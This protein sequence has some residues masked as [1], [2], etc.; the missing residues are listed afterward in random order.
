MYL[1]LVKCEAMSHFI[2]HNVYIRTAG[3]RAQY[4]NDCISYWTY[5][6]ELHEK[7]VNTIHTVTIV[8]S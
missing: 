2:Y 5:T 8:F 7:V 3:L 1:N 6:K 4:K